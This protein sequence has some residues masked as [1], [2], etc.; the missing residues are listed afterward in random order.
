MEGSGV[1][2][3]VFV[4]D[5]QFETGIA[6]IDRQ[7]QKL[8]QLINKLG[9]LLVVETDN[10]RYV[11][12]L[13]SVLRELSN[14]VVY[15]FKFEQTLMERYQCDAAHVVVHQHAHGEFIQQ[16]SEA[17]RSATDHPAAVTGQLI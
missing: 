4:W 13:S 11:K 6:T 16:I 1:L 14:Y 17:Q 9:T 12:S 15:H 8:V 7:H 2:S 10:K 3:D 5:H